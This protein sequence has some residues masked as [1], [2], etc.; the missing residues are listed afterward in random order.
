[1]EHAH[2]TDLID[3][4]VLQKIQDSFAAATRLHVLTRDAAGQEVTEH[5]HPTPLCDLIDCEVLHSTFGDPITADAARA[6]APTRE[7][8]IGIVNFVE[9][10][11]FGD[12]SFGHIEMIALIGGEPPSPAYLADLAERLEMDPETLRK[13]VAA[14]T[15]TG[16]GEVDAA[17]GLLRSIAGVLSDLCR[18]SHESRQKVRELSTLYD[19]STMLTQTMD[20]RGR[21]SILTRKATET[22]G[23]K[24][25]LI[26]L[27]DDETG[28]L[29]VKAVHNLS[30]RYLEKGSVNLADSAVD[31]E[32]VL[33]RVVYLPDVTR[34]HRTLYPTEAAEEGL[35]SMLC[36]ALRSRGRVIGTIRV[37]TGRPHRF[38]DD[39]ARLF[40]AIANQAAV[41][42]ENAAL[43]EEAVRAQAL[44]REL[45]AAAEIQGHLFPDH[46]PR[47][48]GFD[49]ASRYIP[50]GSVGG[51]F[52]DFVP[53]QDEHVGIVIGD[54]AGKGV[55]AAI[56]MAATRAVLR[57][58]IDTIF[59][60][61]DIVANTNRSLCRDIAA[62]QFVTL[63]YGAL[64]TVS[65]RF[66]YCNAGHALPLIFRD[67]EHC[68]LIEGGMAIGV[69]PE[70]PYEEA[71]FTLQPGDVLVFY[72]DGLTETTDPD[73]EMFGRERIREAVA[74][75][76]GLPAADLLDHLSRAAR[77]FA[78]GAPATDDFTLIVLKAL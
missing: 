22:L 68:A 25:C 77:A 38:T 7:R 73:L 1:M 67:G 34:D 42:I 64:D 71:Q 62:D 13:L 8:P 41:A 23:V 21:L 35:A 18:A 29:V 76:A 49:I 54:V 45:D 32:A 50:F 24:G 47:I 37:Y 58:H 44:D 55:P 31:Q 5:A 30:Q 56:L 16:P 52:Y 12:H 59:A 63:F 2:L 57:G 3:P 39:E 78:R 43:Y 40:Q 65:R 69:D 9:P 17:R 19:V 4:A 26:R 60:A 20:L 61:R 33:G 14:S 36:V 28:E 51:D 48:D 72:T 66:T 27:I 10:I 46:D 75:H 15:A 74:P 11:E 53:V 70:A 6:W